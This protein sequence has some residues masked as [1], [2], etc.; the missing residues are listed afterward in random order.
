[1]FVGMRRAAAALLCLCLCL[2][3]CG[4][5]G[6]SSETSPAVV[7]TPAQLTA[8]V[9]P[10]VSA[11]LSVRARPTFTTSGTV[12]VVVIDSAGV[13]NPALTLTPQTDGSYVA[14]LTTAALPAG[15]YT[16]SFEV[17]ICP[18]ANC[19]QQFAGSPVRLPFDFTVGTP[20]NLT[21]LSPLAGAPDWETHQGNVAHTGHVP[22]TLDA[23]R[24]NVRWRWVTPNTGTSASA[25]V[26]ANDTVY[27]ST[28]GYF[29]SKSRL[30]ALR[31]SDA[32]ERWAHDFGAVFALNPPAVSGGAVFAATSGHSDTAMWSFD[33][34]DGTQRFRTPF[35]SQWEH[36]YAPAV[37]GGTVYTNGGSYGGMN[38]FDAASG[39]N[40]WFAS[41]AQYDQW[42][43][44]LDADHAYAVMAG[45]LS[46][47]NRSDG[48]LA[49]QVALS[50][51]NW[52]GYESR[53][54]AVLAGA[55]RVL[56]RSV[57]S[58]GANP[59]S[60]TLSLIDTVAGAVTWSVAG[61]FATDPVLAN[62]VVYIANASPLQLEARSL[63]TGA[64]LWTWSL[65]GTQDTGFIGNLIV[66]GSHVF[67]GSNRR[68]FAID[69]A[70]HAAAWTYNRTGQ[71]A[72]SANGVLYIVT[73]N[74]DGGSD[75]GVTAINLR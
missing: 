37:S 2:V 72:I 13:I 63:A 31:E 44:A 3:A 11:P 41:L 18:V 53:T 68:T 27:L 73:L 57:A 62:G 24:F 19:A 38:A 52:N 34:A 56:A 60:N 10:G 30:V 22:V 49:G 23:S 20:S 28:S 16:G 8:E 5:G 7:F 45:Q 40:R 70:S 35:N 58:A 33:A 71:R 42:T 54:M 36:Y 61:T 29:A 48:S 25:A 32:S 64:L 14:E 43:P 75:G 55:G 6:G 47:L 66:T 26:L 21:P 46:V 15:H 69:L 39:T 17:R 50:G 4:G 67:V 51:Y 9:D 74:A 1:M 65:P 12:Y 59:P